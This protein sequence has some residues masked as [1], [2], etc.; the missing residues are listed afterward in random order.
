MARQIVK[1]PVQAIYFSGEEVILSSYDAAMFGIVSGPLTLSL[2][3]GKKRVLV[4]GFLSIERKVHKTN[5]HLYFVYHFMPNDMDK[6]RSIVE[7][8][9]NGH[10]RDV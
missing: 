10:R 3:Y 1:F 8:A 9:E 7:K 5:Y 2:K 4:K 6:L